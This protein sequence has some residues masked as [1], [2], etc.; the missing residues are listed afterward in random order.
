MVNSSFQTL[1]NTEDS[2][3]KR[4]STNL[5]ALPTQQDAQSQAWA[6]A[7]TSGARVFVCHI[8]EQGKRNHLVFSLPFNLLLEIGK[9]TDCRYQKTQ[10]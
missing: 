10:V 3:G 6:D 5:I 4:S 8:Y 9:I 1:N 7:S 2:N